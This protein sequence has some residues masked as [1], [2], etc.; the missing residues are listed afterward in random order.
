MVSRRKY[1][2]YIRSFLGSNGEYMLQWCSS[3]DELFVDDS[4]YD[5]KYFYDSQYIM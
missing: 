4:L 3:D 1:S 2:T 5:W